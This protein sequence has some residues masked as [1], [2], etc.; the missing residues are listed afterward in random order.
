METRTIGGIPLKEVFE[1]LKGDI[2]NVIKYTDDGKPYLDVNTMRAFFDSVVPLQ[3][4]DFTVVDLKYVETTNLTTTGSLESVEIKQM[5]NVKFKESGNR[6]CFTCVGT[7]T[8]YDDFG[9]KVV[10]KSHIGSSNVAFLRATGQAKDMAMDAKNAVVAARKDCIR[11]FGCGERQIEEAKAVKKGRTS[12]YGEN[13]NQSRGTGSSSEVGAD[14]STTVKPPTGV[15]TFRVALD[16]SQSIRDDKNMVLVPIFCKDYRN[17]RTMLQIWKNRMSSD[18]L[19][20]VMNRIQTGIEFHVNGKF[21]L[22][23]NKYRIVFS[24]IEGV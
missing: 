1:K 15:A 6:A 9:Q 21:E 13:L 19:T 11:L 4:Y 3:N 24:R 23:G 12:G 5:E 8:L 7:I 17:Y 16:S 2:P 14:A 18:K 20:E 22:F 10:S